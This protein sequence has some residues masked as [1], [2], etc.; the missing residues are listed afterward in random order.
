MIIV[1]KSA[2]YER[3]RDKFIKYHSKRGNILIRTLKKF[4]HNP[5]YPSLHLEKLKGSNT[6]T[7]RMDKGNRIFFVWLD[8]STALFVDIGP[9]DKYR[10]Y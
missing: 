9:H 2:R 5:N 8:K 3:E 4:S 1:L 10:K 7:I 6:W